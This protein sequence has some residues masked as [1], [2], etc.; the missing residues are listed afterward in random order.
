MAKIRTITD[1]LRQAIIDSGKSHRA[2]ATATGI[3]R[4]SIYRFVRGDQSIRLDVADKLA[5]Y[6]GIE[7]RVK[8]K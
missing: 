8:G 5:E 3:Q 2:I 4:A 1:T 6:F 7:C